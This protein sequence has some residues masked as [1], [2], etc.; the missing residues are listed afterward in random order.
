MNPGDNLTAVV[1][2]TGTAITS[3]LQLTVDTTKF[4][5]KIP[6]V[7]ALEQLTNYISEQSFPL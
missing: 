2:A 4:T 3:G 6:L 1:Q 7:L 5:S